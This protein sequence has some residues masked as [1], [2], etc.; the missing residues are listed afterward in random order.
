MMSDSDSYTMEPQIAASDLLFFSF[1]HPKVGLCMTTADWSEKTLTKIYIFVSGRKTSK[2]EK[3]Q[4]FDSTRNFRSIVVIL[5][6]ANY[7]NWY[8]AAQL[9]R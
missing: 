8:A 9:P 3:I 6:L 2:K 1:M 5:V 4:I 7:A